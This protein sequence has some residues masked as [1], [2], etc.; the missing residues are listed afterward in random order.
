MKPIS[1][2]KLYEIS[3]LLRE[4]EAAPLFIVGGFVRNF[5]VSGV[6]EGD[7]DIASAVPAERFAAL[8]EEAGF[9]VVAFYKRTGTAVVECGEEKYEYTAFRKELYSAGGGHTPAF[10]VPTNDIEEDARRRDFKCNAVYYDIY[11]GEIT[12]VLGGVSDIKNKILDT[13]KDPEEVFESDGLRLMR[14][15]RFSGELGFKPTKE[16]LAA[17]K[18]YSS[19]IAD[20]SP[21]RIF[22]ELK[23]ILVADTKYDF[24]DK[25]GHY[26]GLKILSETRGLDGIIPELTAG[27][28][29]AQRADYHKYDVLEH[30][31]KAVYYA[32]KE[33]RLAALFHDVAK[34]FC[35]INYGEYYGHAGVGEKMTERILSALRADKKTIK[36]TAFLVGAHMKDLDCKEK[37]SKIRRFIAE[38]SPLIPKLLLL[39]QADYSASKDDTGIGPTV[40]KWQKIIEKMR[41]DGTPFSLK[42]LKITAGD[43]MTAGYKGGEI[44][45]ELKKLLALCREFPERNDREI[46]LKKAEK[47]AEKSD[48]KRNKRSKRF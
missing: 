24:S 25:A 6:A 37:E 38:N 12:D 48:E 21:E 17:A 42:E 28:G 31:L 40:E 44:G 46:L 9:N 3:R 34:P 39:K 45:K 47:D 22:D 33:V 5:L 19:N 16:T 20:I 10:T 13:V 36:E 11:R 14:L 43:L 29:M 41:S 27:R 35:K 8:A 2:E 18:K 15:A 1:S 30:S 32:E 4:K 23:R 7:L 26:T